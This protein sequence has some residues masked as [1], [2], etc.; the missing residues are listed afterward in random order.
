MGGGEAEEQIMQEE[1]E[2]CSVVALVA[3]IPQDD[4]IM[5]GQARPRTRILAADN[6]FHKSRRLQMPIN[7]LSTMKRNCL[8]S[9]LAIFR[10]PW[11]LWASPSITPEAIQIQRLRPQDWGR[12]ILARLF[13]AELPLLH[14]QCLADLTMNMRD[15]SPLRMT[16][17]PSQILT[18]YSQS[19]APHFLRL[20]EDSDTIDIREMLPV[21][22]LV[23]CL[24]TTLGQRKLDWVILAANDH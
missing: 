7:L 23:G 17:H 6:P 19:A 22:T 18:I 20:Q 21:K 13:Q 24:E 2:H 15:T 3:P 5:Y 12:L 10:P 16:E 1:P 4:M 11:A 9:T 14:R 8:R